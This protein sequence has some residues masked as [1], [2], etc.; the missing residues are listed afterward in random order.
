MEWT[1]TNVFTRKLR[2][3]DGAVAISIRKQS[4]AYLGYDPEGSFLFSVTP[5][6]GRVLHAKVGEKAFDAV[7][8][9]AFSQK[10]AWFRPARADRIEF[11]WNGQ[12]VRLT[13]TERR[14]FAVSAPSTTGGIT[15][16]LGIKATVRLSTESDT[17]AALLYLFAAV[18]L[19]EDDI[20]VV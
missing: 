11:P 12:V 17:L 18:M 1:V 10:S 14:A 4:K 13:Q 6:S 16:M 15:G 5:G 19:H 9:T 7:M 2:R 8:R 3:S 20:D